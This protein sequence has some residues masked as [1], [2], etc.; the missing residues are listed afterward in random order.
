MEKQGYE[1]VTLN[2]F[3]YLCRIAKGWKQITEIQ[4]SIHEMPSGS[5]ECFPNP[6]KGVLNFS[7]PI[8]GIINCYDTTGRLLQ[9]LEVN[10]ALQ[11]DLNPLGKGIFY[12]QTRDR[13]NSILSYKVVI[14]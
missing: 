2:E 6:T 5:I 8:S 7:Q 9:S 11:L 14:I 13:T 12:L 4:T 1:F 3:D 10:N